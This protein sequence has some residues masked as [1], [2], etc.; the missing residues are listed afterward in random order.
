MRLIIIGGVAGG[1]SAAARARRLSES[2]EII[3]FERGPYIS[4]ANCGLPYYI[5]GDI[6]N[7]DDLIVTSVDMLRTRFNIDVRINTEIT[8][9]NVA[10]KTVT[11]YNHADG[12]TYTEKYDKIVLAPGAEPIKPPMEGIDLPGIYSLRTIPD[13]DRIN[14]AIG[15]EPRR[16]T[17]VGAGYI[18]LEMAEALVHRGC[19]VRIV[20][21]MPQV[22]P[23]FDPDMATM[24][25]SKLTN[26][27]VMVL[28]NTMVTGFEQTEHGISITISPGRKISQ[29]KKIM[30]DIV[31]LSVGVRPETKLAQEAGL[32]IGST[33]AIKVNGSMQTSNQD[34][35]AV[36]D[37]VEVKHLP[38]NIPARIPLAG[39]AN[40]Q[41]RIAVDNIFG[42]SSTY[43]GTQ[44]TSIVRLFDLTAAS[45]GANEKQLRHHNINFEKIYVHPKDHAGYYPGASGMTIKLLFSLDDG[46]VLGAQIVGEDGVDKRIDV[47]SMAI[48]ANMTVYD[49]EEVELAYAPPF[50]SAKD[51]VNMAGFVA[52]NTLRGDQPVT[53]VYTVPE[54]AFILD[55]RTPAEYAKGAVP[56]AKSIPLH[57]LRSRL[58]E[59]PK[60]KPVISYCHAGLRSYVAVRILKNNGYDVYNLS[61]GY[62]TYD[63]CPVQDD[64]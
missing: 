34:I 49:L 59:I 39:P 64:M 12:T 1:A 47:F 14:Q 2:A 28:L 11:A 43:R 13:M 33:G 22:M 18:G 58:N 17:I 21:A 19:D 29:T 36:G 3:L 35:Y 38:L 6:K 45:T 60:D 40:R 37:A 31:V 16:V 20:E 30:T 51:P 26:K 42:R 54:D 9:I 10:D 61:G 15:S 52:A 27:G 41:G 57:E 50:G 46:S 63:V 7:K 8:H 25:Q 4:F 32:E 24:L 44:G 48:Q 62:L 23:P 5:G 56:G 53:H 55:V